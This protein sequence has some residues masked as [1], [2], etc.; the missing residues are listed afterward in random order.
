ME[1]GRDPLRLGL[2]NAITIDGRLNPYASPRPIDDSD[3]EEILPDDGS[4]DEPIRRDRRRA[5]LRWMRDGWGLSF[6]AALFRIVAA[7]SSVS[8]V[9]TTIMATHLTI[10]ATA[11]VVIGQLVSSRHHQHRRWVLSSAAIGV[12]ASI[13]AA[14]LTTIGYSSGGRPGIFPLACASTASVWLLS[15]ATAGLLSVDRPWRSRGLVA[16]AVVL[17]GGAGGLWCRAANFDRSCVPSAM[18]WM[19]LGAGLAGGAMAL[20]SFAAHRNRR[21]MRSDSGV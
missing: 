5:A 3:K 13:A 15:Q 2:L 16:A 9:D 19:T 12:A 8:R 17:C 10:A 18:P 6:V 1:R 4:L 21:S 20:L 14:V 11:L 7:G